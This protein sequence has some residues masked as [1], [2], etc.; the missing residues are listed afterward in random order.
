ML[1]LLK[2]C[3]VRVAL[4]D[5]ASKKGDCEKY[6][7]TVVGVSEHLHWGEQAVLPVF[8]WM[9]PISCAM[10]GA[11]HWTSSR[12]GCCPLAIS[13]TARIPVNLVDPVSGFQSDFVV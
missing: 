6:G 13:N 12:G 11:V 4:L 1:G 10:A 7:S 2:A 9:P 8:V 3:V 5:M